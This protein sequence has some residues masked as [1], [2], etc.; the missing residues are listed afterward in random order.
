MRVLLVDDEPDVRALLK[1][2]ISA[3]CEGVD[4]VEEASDGVEAVRKTEA[5]HPDVVVMD[6]R[7][8]RMNGVEATKRIKTASPEV[9]VVVYSV[10]YEAEAEAKAAGATRQFLKGDMS[11]LFRY[12]CPAN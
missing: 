4:V 9:D 5:T 8:P 6:L 12:L 3:Y 10:A 1:M 7:M 2:A 11:G